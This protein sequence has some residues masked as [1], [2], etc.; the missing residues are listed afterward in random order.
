MS[1]FYESLK[2]NKKKK[3]AIYMNEFETSNIWKLNTFYG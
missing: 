2:I 3:F 1:T